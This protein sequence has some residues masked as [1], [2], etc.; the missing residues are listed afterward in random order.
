MAD[1]F[2]GLARLPSSSVDVGQDALS[3]GTNHR[4]WDRTSRAAAT[5]V[6]AAGVSPR[7]KWEKIIEPWSGG[8]AM[9]QTP[10]GARLPNLPRTPALRAGLD[11]FAPTALFRCGLFHR[12][13]REA[14]RNRLFSAVG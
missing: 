4:D 13:T 7:V 6:L 9:T 11:Y 10:N 5:F 14:C 3:G 12:C 1:Q 2:M 8:T